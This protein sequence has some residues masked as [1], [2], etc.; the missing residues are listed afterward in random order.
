[1]AVA[2]T[3]PISIQA[4]SATVVADVRANSASLAI[5]YAVTNV[6]TARTTDTTFSTLYRP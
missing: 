5:S 4:R 2:T 3:T 1:M 6:M